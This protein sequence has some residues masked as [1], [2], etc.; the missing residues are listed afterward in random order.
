MSIGGKCVKIWVPS[1]P[2][3]QK[4]WCGNLF[5]W[6]QEIFWVRNHFEPDSFTSCGSAAV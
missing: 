1:R 3:H 4:V 2:S 6:F 5:F